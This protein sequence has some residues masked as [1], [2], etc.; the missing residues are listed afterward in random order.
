MNNNNNENVSLENI[1]VG[2][3]LT[4]REQRKLVNTLVIKT[5]LRE[6]KPFVLYIVAIVMAVQGNFIALSIF[7]K[8]FR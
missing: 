8:F 7:T 3:T 4:E 6:I 2:L 1:V 5:I